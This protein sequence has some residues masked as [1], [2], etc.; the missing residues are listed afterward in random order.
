[1]LTLFSCDFLLTRVRVP[2]FRWAAQL[3]GEEQEDAGR[4]GG[5]LPGHSEHVTPLP[6][7][8]WTAVTIHPYTIPPSQ[9]HN[10][11]AH[12][13]LPFFLISNKDSLLFEHLKY[14]FYFILIKGQQCKNCHILKPVSFNHKVPTIE[15]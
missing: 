9:I 8:F 13:T 14:I 10:S 4:D 1:M 15:V 11:L 3:Q 12:N 7:C 5:C 2:V 6:S